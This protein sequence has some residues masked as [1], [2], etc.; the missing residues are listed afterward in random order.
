MTTAPEPNWT[1][2]TIWTGDNLDIMRGMNSATVDLIKIAGRGKISCLLKESEIKTGKHL[3]AV[4]RQG[5]AHATGEA[6]GHLAGK[7]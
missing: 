4:G 2:Q 5:I 7:A 1:D 3:G 6:I